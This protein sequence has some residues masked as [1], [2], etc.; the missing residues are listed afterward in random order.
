M[1]DDDEPDS[2]GA[3]LMKITFLVHAM[4]GL[5][6]TIRTTLNTASALADRGHEVEIVSVVR[7]GTQPRLEFDPRVRVMSLLDKRPDSHRDP[8]DGGHIRTGRDRALLE[9]P[10][11]AF[12]KAETIYHKYSALTDRRIARFLRH[13]RTDVYVGTRP[14][15]NVYLS[16]FAAGRAVLVGQEHMF[17][18]YHS[19]AL[20]RRM[21]QAY[22]R[23]DA[24]VT[25]TAADADKYRETMPHLAD[26]IHFIPNTVPQCRVEPADGTSR[27]IIAAGRI[28]KVKRYDLLIRAFE[29][30]VA[31]HPDWKLR[32]Y[33]VGSEVENL[34][35]LIGQLGLNNSVLLMGAHSPIDVEWVKGSIAAVTSEYE[36]FGLT[37]IEAMSAGLPVVST[38][39]RM[40]PL[41]LI[42]DEVD[43]LLV[44]PGDTG[45]IASGLRKLIENPDLRHRMSQAAQAKARKF[46]PDMVVG[47][48]EALFQS[49]HD[50]HHPRPRPKLRLRDTLTKG[51]Y[52][53][54]DRRD[55]V[56]SAGLATTVACRARAFDELRI[57]VSGPVQSARLVSER[58][59]P[60]EL[61]LE[62][63]PGGASIDLPPRVWRSMSAGTWQL[64]VDG[65]MPKVIY[66]DSR[67]LAGG[68]TDDG[69]PL[70]AVPYADG[71]CLAIRLWKRK[72][73]AEMDHVRW[74]GASLQIEGD[75]FGGVP[76]PADARMCLKSAN[77]ST[78][79]IDVPLS[80]RGSR[81]SALID[82]DELRTHHTGEHDVWHPY[83]LSSAF[84][85]GRL[86][87]GRF[88]DDIAN[89]R[90][91]VRF[92]ANTIGKVR[93]EPYCMSDN[94][95][96]IR[97]TGELDVS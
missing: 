35:D 85:G 30:V 49:L 13:H 19:A 50:T 56:P 79:P 57:D 21:A 45:A 2:T 5:G 18:D 47:Q 37:I 59:S 66:V 38:A 23:L 10:S 53:K 72:L 29:E 68:R 94:Q 95:L 93:V 84:P 24:F 51:A 31:G 80:L 54:L 97:V 52:R 6:G 27:T 40:G 14:G 82:T 61:T 48:H 55:V 36:S 92:P 83:L 8:A 89:K 4:Y 64:E 86:R 28:E 91:I 62:P 44:T 41:E 3:S 96:A 7:A 58:H 43:G 69:V 90:R 74:V 17:H 81:F 16:Q 20:R 39:C 9:Q 73:Y 88:F 32:I 46:A 78:E 25:V 1:E 65:S 70:S 26:R 22:R 87:P 67:A 33:G 76:V 12:P 75:V 15:L 71:G 42:D 34:R 63:C 77:G 11:A 60:V